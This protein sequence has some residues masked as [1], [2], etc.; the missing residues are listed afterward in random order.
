[1]GSSSRKTS[2]LSKNV[3][4]TF[5]IVI[6]GDTN[7][8]KSSL[9]IRYL[10]DEFKEAIANTI[11]ISNDFKE[12]LVDGN[13]V[14]LQM[15]DTAGQERFKSIVS[16][17]YRDADGFI[18]VYD[19]NISRTFSGMKNLIAELSSILNPK[20]TV[21][22]GNK[23]DCLEGEAL[24][25]ERGFLQDFAAKNKFKYFFTSAKTGESV[26]EVFEYLSRVL[27]YNTDVK[28][29]P[30]NVLTSIFKKKKSFCL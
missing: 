8:G 6:L 3:P 13:P 1:M 28:T 27:Y 12:V 9:F 15:W 21:L 7:V 10:R 22:V 23:I 18:F 2:E 30:K 26:N 19:V 14:H 11:A 29:K 25:E 4:K 20:F 24:E 17:L 5:K 16:Q